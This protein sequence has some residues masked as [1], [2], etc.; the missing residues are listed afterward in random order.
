MLN[1]DTGINAVL[2]QR[3][4]VYP[5]YV[6]R[7][8]ALDD[9]CLRKLFYM[10][11]A[12]DKAT[13]TNN[14]LQG[15]FETGNI[16]EPVIERIVSEVGAASTP[17]WRI[18][19]TQVTTN[20]GLLKQYQISGTIDGMIQAQT[21][22]GW[23]TLGVVDIKTMSPNVFPRI[24]T[25]DDLARYPWTAKYRGQ[26]MLYA[27]AHNLDTCFLLLVNKSNLYQMRLIEFPVDLEYCE[28][29]LQK[30]AAVNEAVASDMAPEGINEPDACEHC[31][32]LSYCC[33]QLTRHNLTISDN[34][35]LEAIL[36]R[37]ADLKETAAEYKELEKERDAL[38]VKGED[39]VCGKWVVTWKQSER[40]EYTVSAATVWT[41]KII[42][43]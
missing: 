1:I 22:E 37:L 10:R 16:L 7:I 31:Q 25:V 38:L 23:K 6:N 17:Q 26:V 20:D 2:E 13:P 11:A 30:A 28:R 42:K 12:W 40:K 9:P 35:E 43:A 8:S 34:I 29:L 5:Q 41:K 32:F 27:L 14:S 33:P 4:R 36:D 19:G 21:A 18:V 15:V 39:M 24:E 3:K